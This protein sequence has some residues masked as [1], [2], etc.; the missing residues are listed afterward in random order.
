[1]SSITKIDA[2]RRQLNVAIRLWFESGDPIAIYCLA[3]SA[4]EIIHD[5]KER[6]GLRDLYYDSL[7]IKDEYQKEWRQ[8]LKAPYNFLKHADKDPDD[9][10]EFEP[11]LTE[12]FIVFSLIGLKVL[13]QTISDMGHVYL[14]WLTLHHPERLT[15]EGRGLYVEPFPTELLRR[16]RKVSKAEFFKIWTKKYQSFPLTSISP[17]N[18]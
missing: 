3:C 7:V 11:S 18:I 1:V 6:K 4:Y 15:D 8:K 14:I 12:P 5:L 17:S 2:A 9:V 16:V 10:L 13:G